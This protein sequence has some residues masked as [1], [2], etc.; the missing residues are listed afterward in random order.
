MWHGVI[1]RGDTVSIKIGKNSIVQDLTYLNEPLPLQ[2]FPIPKPT[3]SGK[4]ELEQTEFQGINIKDNVVIGPQCRIRKATF[5]NNSFVGAKSTVG[6]GCIIESYAALAAG[7]FL[8]DG[9]V[10]PS[11]QIWAGNPAKYLRDLSVEEK[12]AIV[13]NVEQ[14]A[15]LARIYAQET[16]KTEREVLDEK[17][18][19]IYKKEED[20]MEAHAMYLW[21]K[22]YPLDDE[23][24]EYIDHRAR[25]QYSSSFINEKDPAIFESNP[26]YY[27]KKW[28]PL[29]YDVAKMSSV[30]KKYGVNTDMYESA[31]QRYKYDQPNLEAPP[32]DHMH[33]PKDQGP[34][35]K[36]FDASKR[37]TPMAP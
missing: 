10:V 35:E 18:Q 5:E 17:L 30:L 27:K 25:T 26:D 34:W 33:I 11:G 21:E 13:E 24:L 15:E 23:D 12:L 2:G 20:L 3:P 1:A 31:Y 8:Q 16:E 7:A 29:A 28:E 6:D 36:K 4:N 19:H 37:K 22:G 32:L 14:L 9:K